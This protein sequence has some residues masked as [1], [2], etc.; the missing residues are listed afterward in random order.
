MLR[1]LEDVLGKN[2]LRDLFQLRGS[3]ETEAEVPP[4]N[5]KRIDL[6]FVPD[7][8]KL[9]ANARE[10]TGILVAITENPAA[11][12][13]WS[14]PLGADDFHA[15]LA[16]REV[17]REILELRDKRPWPR[18]I[19]WHICAGKPETVM[20]E[21][22]FEPA[23]LPGWYR[24]SKRGLRVQIVVVGELPKTRSTLLFRLLAR[25]RVRHDALRE[26]RELPD[27]AWE[28]QLAHPW[29]VRLGLEVPLDRVEAP[30]D[31]E[32]VM[33][34]QAWY[35]EH[36]QKLRDEWLRDLHELRTED[37]QAWY[38]DFLETHDREVEARVLRGLETQRVEAQRQAETNQ[39]VRQF[40]HR[41]ARR[42]TTNECGMLTARIETHGSAHLA[43][44]VLDL[45]G[46]ELTAWFEQQLADARA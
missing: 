24:P 42:L 23:E 6:W 36:N 39:L 35:K 22:G 19:L 2:I 32:F 5:A 9:A 41:L 30:E 34:I 26:L 29:L 33:D 20:E 4:G 21:F 10:F 12:E 7:K 28:K 15:T 13:L 27:D 8:D 45:S 43:D 37:V 31:R 3:A 25:G 38:K 16:K 18:P 1:N 44:L 40:E 17:W 14:A 46:A 11:I